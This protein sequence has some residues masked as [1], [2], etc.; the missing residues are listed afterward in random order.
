MIPKF[1]Y[2]SDLDQ[3]YK[4]AIRLSSKLINQYVKLNQVDSTL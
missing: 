4:E 1:Y 2:Y 3:G